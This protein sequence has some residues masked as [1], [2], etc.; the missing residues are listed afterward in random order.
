MSWTGSPKCN[1]HLQRTTMVLHR[2]QKWGE[3]PFLQLFRWG[4]EAPGLK[5]LQETSSIFCGQPHTHSLQMQ[6]LFCLFQGTRIPFTLELSS[7]SALYISTAI[8]ICDTVF[9]LVCLFICLFIVFHPPLGVKW[10]IPKEPLGQRFGFAHC[11]VPGRCS[12]NICWID[13]W[14]NPYLEK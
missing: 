12:I 4:P 7:P 9:L 13:E 6:C 14:M 1:P 10:K 5:V 3:G 11:L 2:R 8:N